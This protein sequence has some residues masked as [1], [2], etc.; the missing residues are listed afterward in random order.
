V[1]LL[2]VFFITLLY[3]KTTDLPTS[4]PN[5]GQRRAMADGFVF[6]ESSYHFPHI[7]R[8]LIIIYTSQTVCPHPSQSGG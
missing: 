7:A 3:N 6:S 2:G 4:F 1:T 8:W 5:K